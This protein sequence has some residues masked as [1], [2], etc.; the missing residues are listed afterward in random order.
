MQVYDA[1]RIVA[2]ARTQLQSA[3]AAATVDTLRIPVLSRRQ[4]NVGQL[5]EVCILCSSVLQWLL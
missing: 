2:E 5:H 1:T 3:D 4:R